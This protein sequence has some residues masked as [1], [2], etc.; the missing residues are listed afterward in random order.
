M[1][2]YKI[3]LATI[4]LGCGRKK[5]TDTVDPTAGIEF[6]KKIGDKVNKGSTLF[7]FFNSDSSKLNPAEKLLKD[8]IQIDEEKVIHELFLD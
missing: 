8:S 3:G 6:Y 2:T 7:N 4:E 1:D 5:T